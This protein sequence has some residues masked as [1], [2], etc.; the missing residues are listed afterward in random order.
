MD[1]EEGDFVTWLRVSTA[2]APENLFVLV[3]ERESCV[4]ALPCTDREHCSVLLLLEDDARL[5]GLAPF[6]RVATFVLVPCSAP[7]SVMPTHVGARVRAWIA[8]G[9]PWSEVARAEALSSSEGS[10]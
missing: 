6:K 2:D 4:Q 7:A 8:S 9:Q 1:G 10:E 5:V 3:R